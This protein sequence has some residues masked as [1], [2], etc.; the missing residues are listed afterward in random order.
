MASTALV[1]LRNDLRI[2]DN[3]AL[4]A[5]L[6]HGRVVALHVEA[7]DETLRRRGS[8]SRWWLNRSLRALAVD[9]ADIGVRLVTAEGESEEIAFETL[10]A[11]GADAL[12]WNRRYG[13]AEREID[14]AIKLRGRSEGIAV[15]SFPGSVLVEPFDIATGSG[16]PYSVFT[17]FWK[18]LRTR[19]IAAPRSAPSA[20]PPISP[21]AVD[22][23]YRTPTWATK[24]DEH[25][26]PGERAALARLHS[27]L[28]HQLAGYADQR[29]FPT[30]S[31]TSQLSPHLAFGEISPRQI[32]HSAQSVAHS[33]PEAAAAVDKFLSELAWRD[34]NYTQY[35]HRTD[36]A[37]VP[38]QERFSRLSWREDDAALAAWKQ[39]RT[40]F[41]IVD[42][43]MREL[44]ATGTMHN[45]V[46]MLVASLVC[47]NLLLDWRLGEQWFWDTL[48][49]ADPASNPGNWQWVAGSGL[50]ASPFFRIFNPVTQGERFDADGRYVR[51]WV[52]ELAL[53]PNEW[54]HEPFEAPPAVL[55]AAGVDLEANYPAP[56]VDLKMSRERALEALKQL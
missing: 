54:L 19:N 12:F 41:P 6:A 47:K 7:T 28:E 46:R 9:L 36:I 39:G 17:P 4:V 26:Q 25:W 22:T 34:F 53:L 21:D 15:E 11:H 8:A 51:R 23:G 10:R 50:D 35:F 52:P 55:R 56:I 3:P 20:A 2:A 48:V 45:R 18:T 38:M 49:D 27:F 13:P 40:G 42:A 32:W 5:G 14:A 16:G 31:V 43:G 29:D 30:H 37:N 24:F 1:W 44:W 33:R